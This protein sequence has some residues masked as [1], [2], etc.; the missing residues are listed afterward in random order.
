MNPAGHDYEAQRELERHA[1]RNV[2]W[3]AE[4]LGYRDALDK[5]TEKMV[6][7]GI[8]GF[9]FVALGFLVTGILTAE[10]PADEMA[11]RRCEVQV[12]ADETKDVREK[13]FREHPEMNA[14]QRGDFAERILKTLMMARCTATSPAR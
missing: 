13:V 8:A 14:V 6:V 3:L 7:I 10:T 11:H 1:L 2:S 5:R 4:K 9:A 12:R